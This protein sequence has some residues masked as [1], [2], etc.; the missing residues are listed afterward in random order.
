MSVIPGAVPF[1]GFVGP[2]DS[3]DTYP[4]TNP[5]YGLGG[6]RSVPDMT[7]LSAIT[8]QRREPG[9]LVFVTGTS[10]YYQLGSGLTNAEWTVFQSGSGAGGNNFLP[11]SGGVVTGLSVFNG[12]LSA[13]S[14]STS[15]SS[16]S[17]ILLSASTDL[18]NIFALKNS[19]VQSV[20]P[21][22]NINTGGT[23]NKPIV[24]L[25]SSPSLNGLTLSGNLIS[26]GNI[27]ANQITGTTIYSGGS[28]LSTLFL[29]ISASFVEGSGQANYIPLWQNS[30][31][32]IASNIYQDPTT[33]ITIYDNVAITGDFSVL[34]TAF[35][36][37]TQT[38]QSSDNLIILNF[39]GNHVSAV[40]GGLSVTSGQT[41]GSP[42]LW[43]IDNNGNWSANTQIIAGGGL[44]VNTGT[45][46]SSGGTDLY[47]IFVPWSAS[48]ASQT[49]YW[50]ASTGSNSL[51]QNN[52]QG[53]IAGGVNSFVAAGLNNSGITNFSIIFNGQYNLALGYSS[54]IGNGQANTATSYYSSVLNGNNNIALNTYSTVVNGRKNIALGSHS[55]I[56]NGYKNSALDVY[57]FIGNGI[58]NSATTYGA[59]VVGGKSNLASSRLNFIGGGQGNTTKQ[60]FASILGGQNN[61]ANGSYSTIGGGL[62]NKTNGSQSFIGGGRLNKAYGSYSIVVGGRSNYVN[63]YNGFISN[64][65]GN[66]VSGSF[67]SIIGGRLNTVSN[68]KSIIGAGHDNTITTQNSAIVAGYSNTIDTQA[69]NAFI[70]SGVFNTIN[71]SNDTAI[72]GGQNNSIGGNNDL[73]FIGGGH[74]NQITNY[75]YRSVLAG[76][77]SNHIDRSEGTFIGAGTT[78]SVSSAK[79]S[80]VGGGKSNAISGQYSSIVGGK[81]NQTQ[82]PYSAI[83]GGQGNV[84]SANNSFA[85]GS[86]LTANVANTTFIE[87]ARLAETSGSKIY[88]ASTPLEQIFAPISISGG[89]SG[90]FLPISGGTVTG[91]T[92][93]T[94]NITASTITLTATTVAPINIPVLITDPGTLHNGDLWAVSAITGS[95]YLN[96]RIGGTTK[97]VELT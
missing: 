14:F 84:I 13:S 82:N 76:G 20:L 64:G 10:I 59:I 44:N 46:L 58:T 60:Y 80:V 47:D 49:Q 52:S 85:I 95:V 6:L 28:D 96:F 41:S 86:N 12:G 7:S 83:L 61:I 53:N 29:P 57:S 75:S 43:I 42:S 45:T 25:V 78:N 4:V 81:N 18:Y 92:I 93:F 17:G 51:I 50:T 90:N 22:T 55:I 67:S 88:S 5:I 34:G 11:L 40:G 71:Y 32:L 15:G 23:P 19:G 72:V 48:G 39:S 9:M 24:S 74:L 31:T 54:L 68:Q 91:D 16:N 37:N 35:T 30:S 97:T 87:N 89:T 36:V 2:T 63:A 79:Y 70:G 62:A 56:G 38:V 21:G 8:T 1:A 94:Q 65:Q 69:Y 3:T 77:I 66:N 26:S 73:S 27:S 33:G